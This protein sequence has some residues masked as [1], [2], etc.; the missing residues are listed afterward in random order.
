MKRGFA[1]VAAMALMLTL[2]GCGEEKKAKYTMGTGNI[3]GI[4]YSYGGVLGQLIQDFTGMTV[5][6]E[7]TAGSKE[8]IM[9]IASGK[10]QLAMTQSDV[11]SYAWQGRRDFDGARVDSLRVVAGLYTEPIQLISI[12]PEI[13]YAAD[14][15]RG[16]RV[17]VGLPDS[18]IFFNAIDVLESVSLTLED[19]Q[20][21]YLNVEDTIQ[22]LKDGTVDAAFLVSGA[23]APALQAISDTV[24]FTLIPIEGPIAERIQTSCPFYVPH[25]IP[26]GTYPGQNLRV[27]TLAVRATLAVSAQESTQTVY[28]MTK[29]IFDHKD[30]V[31]SCNPR[32]KELDPEKVADGIVVPFHPGAVMYFNENDISLR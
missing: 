27:N 20:P 21:F 17:A 24:K 4:Y 3:S 30:A 7:E 25:T 8:N 26:A 18:G 32:G 16:M 2:A 29:A 19:I 15:L 5:Q 14:E 6:V 23:P 1:W 28:K 11:L 9:G 22:A 10:Y 13:R 12:N 31:R